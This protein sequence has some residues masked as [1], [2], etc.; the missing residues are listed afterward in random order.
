[1]AG[2]DRHTQPAVISD[3]AHGE[4]ALRAGVFEAV[5]LISAAARGT[6]RMP[7]GGDLPPENEAVRFAVADGFSHPDAEVL[8]AHR[9]EEGAPVTLT[10]GFMGLTGPSG[11]LPD[12]YTEAVLQRDRARDPAMQRFFDLF[13]HRAVSLFYRAWAKYRLPVQFGE[14]GGDLSDPVSRVLSALS[15]TPH[16]SDDPLQLAAAATLSRRVRTPSALRRTLA[17]LFDLPVEVIELK[18]RRI[19]I[20]AHERTRL[21]A[22]RGG[23]GRYAALGKTAVT[24]D[25]VTDVAG[26]FRLRIGPLNRERFQSFFDDSGARRGLTDTVRAAVG[27]TADFDLQ[28]VLKRADVGSMRLTRETDAPRLGQ[29]SWLLHGPA[30]S[31]RDDAVLGSR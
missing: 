11:V 7:V 29:T 15:G 17:L 26:R 24:G 12:H 16:A 25:T 23:L 10:V 13:N 20:A 21:G 19:R 3:A 31:D 6:R 18:P 8:R 1:M 22:E 9:P 27:A 30:E 2:T 14:T 28:L 5:R 4:D